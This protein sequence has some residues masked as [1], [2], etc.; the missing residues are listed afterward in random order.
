MPPLFSVT[1]SE[2]REGGDAVLPPPNAGGGTTNPAPHFLKRW[3]RGDPRKG[4]QGRDKPYPWNVLPLA[5][6]H[7]GI[8]PRPFPP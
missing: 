8:V 7:R 2:R 3:G 5:L 1:R 4:G 6:R